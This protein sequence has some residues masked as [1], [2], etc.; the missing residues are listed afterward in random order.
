M[1]KHILFVSQSYSDY[2]IAEYTRNT[3]AA[4]D[5][6]TNNLSRAIIKGFEENDCKVDILNYP[7]VGSFPLYYKILFVSGYKSDDGSYESIPYFN[8]M[9]F[10]RK[11]I[12]H[13]MYSR[14]KQWCRKN[15]GE[16]IIFFYA[17]T[18]LPVIEELKDEFCDLKVFVLVAD[19]PEFMSTDNGLV[20]RIHRMMGGEKPSSGSYYSCVDGYILLSEAMKE[21]LPVGKKPYIVVEGIY[22]PEEDNSNVEKEHQKTILYTGDLGRRY[23]IVDL[24]KAFSFINCHD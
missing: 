7:L 8:L 9:Y 11:V 4:L 13:K 5:Y 24:L 22:N 21:R 19:L 16:K 15:E 2:N 17:C 1:N 10:K 6:A 14:I 3:K 20:T 23:G 12:T 18:F